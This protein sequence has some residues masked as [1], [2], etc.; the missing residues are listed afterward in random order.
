VKIIL[1]LYGILL[2][3]IILY[4]YNYM[5]FSRIHFMSEPD[6]RFVLLGDPQ[7]EGAARIE[8]QGFYG[9]MNVWLN[10]VYFRHIMNNIMNFV[11]PTHIFV[12]GDIFSFQSLPDT[13]FNK[14]VS[15]FNWIFSHPN[16]RPGGVQLINIT[17]NHDIGY[18]NEVDPWRVDRF[19]RVFGPTNTKYYIADHLVAVVN[20]QNIDNAQHK[21][22]AQKTWNHLKSIAKESQ[23]S[24]VPVIL[25]LHIPLWKPPGSCTEDSFI[26]YNRD[27]YVEEQ[28]T[29]SDSASK[30]ILEVVK[31]KFIINGH[32][33]YG[34]SY[35]HNEYTTEFT[36]RSMM[37]DFGGHTSVLEI[38][39]NVEGNN[40]KSFTYNYYKTNFV[41]VYGIT[42]LL[43]AIIIWLLL[44][45]IYGI[46]MLIRYR[47]KEKKE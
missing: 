11:H 14:R 16:I 24:G 13:E 34:C 26:K 29:L 15:R 19:E 2:L 23:T 45:L 32:D 33:H 36:I 1:Q 22:L 44:L 31:P 25:F 28:G 20:S 39:S 7:M 4:L 10:D 47:S 21:G 12:M 6:A 38:K 46:V 8:R 35:K 27:G 9:L 3:S 42:A 17:G 37:G 30:Y 5:L 18:A 40:T 41:V 43:I